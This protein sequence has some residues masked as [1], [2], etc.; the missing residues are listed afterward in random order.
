MLISL[1]FHQFKGSADLSIVYKDL[2]TS[3]NIRIKIIN[4]AVKVRRDKNAG[5]MGQEIGSF[6]H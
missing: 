3:L 4:R 5:I 1:I 6:D 2:S